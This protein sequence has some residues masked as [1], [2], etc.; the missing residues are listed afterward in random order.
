MS[1]TTLNHEK[2][3]YHFLPFNLTNLD[4]V[5]QI[6]TE[7]KALNEKMDL[8][9]NDIENIRADIF[10]VKHSVSSLEDTVA[11]LA[12]ENQELKDKITQIE[13]NNDKLEAL[14]R[15]ANLLF[16][17]GANGNNHQGISTKLG[18]DGH[19]L[20]FERV[21]RL[22]TGS[23]SRPIIIK[24]HSLQGQRKGASASK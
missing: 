16:F 1:S 7:M 4:S 8:V 23:E 17:V 14:S 3:L 18:I 6:R 22:N 19:T 12:T 5:M 13:L 24:V 2:E 20:S 11:V 15:R 10:N 9:R 21:H